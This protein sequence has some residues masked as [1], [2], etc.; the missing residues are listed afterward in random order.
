MRAAVPSGR[1][2]RES[3]RTSAGRRFNPES[4]GNPLSTVTGPIQLSL[5]RYS[6]RSPSVLAKSRWTLGPMVVVR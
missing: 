4:I 1:S 6:T 3:R 2:G 5:A